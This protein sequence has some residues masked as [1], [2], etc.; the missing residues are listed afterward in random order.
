MVGLFDKLRG[1]SPHVAPTS[2]EAF[3]TSSAPPPPVRQSLFADERFATWPTAGP[4]E[5][6]GVVVEVGIDGGLDL[7]AAYADHTARYYNHS[8]AGV[9]WERPDGSLDAQIDAL[10]AAARPL[11][12]FVEP[13][14]GELPAPPPVDEARIN[15]LT[16][17]GVRF[18]QGPWDDLA[19]AGGGQVLAAAT[20]LMRSL[21]DLAR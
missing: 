7:L 10:L 4:K 17:A 6:R 8:G 5:L 19:Q 18:G 1:K 9:V 14:A 3:A 20:Q 13:W 21:I 11:C 12:D 16:P 15:M 2:P